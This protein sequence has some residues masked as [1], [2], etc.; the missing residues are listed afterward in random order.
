MCE[1]FLNNVYCLKIIWKYQTNFVTLHSKKN[2]QFMAYYQRREKDL[3]GA[4]YYQTNYWPDSKEGEADVSWLFAPFTV[5]FGAVFKLPFF[6]NLTGFF[7][8][9]PIF[10]LIGMFLG[11]LAALF[12]FIGEVLCCWRDILHEFCRDIAAC[13]K[14][15]MERLVCHK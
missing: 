1:I 11:M 5:L 9:L 10:L 7:A 4:F 15:A 13:Y 3:S 8:G 14:W 12:I 6:R 2:D